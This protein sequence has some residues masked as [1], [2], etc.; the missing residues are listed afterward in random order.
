M[1]N[2]M[3]MFVLCFVAFFEFAQGPITWLYMSE[4]MQDSAVAVATSLNWLV[5]LLLAFFSPYIIKA[6]TNGN[7]VQ[8]GWL[9]MGGAVATLIGT[10][11]MVF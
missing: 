7:D 6:L 3:V 4:I 1:N 2:L 10:I 9:F 8:L 11:I 5:N